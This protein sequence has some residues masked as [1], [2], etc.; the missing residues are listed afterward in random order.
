MRDRANNS[1]EI[2]KHISP[3]HPEHSHTTMMH[4]L[5]PIPVVGYL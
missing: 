2:L 4:P 5:I 1:F 3:A